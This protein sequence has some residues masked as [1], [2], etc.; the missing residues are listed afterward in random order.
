MSILLSNFL[1]QSWGRPLSHSLKIAFLPGGEDYWRGGLE[2]L[3]NQ[4]QAIK[5]T[6]GKKI[7]TFALETRGHT[8]VGELADVSISLSY[9]RRHSAS[10]IV[11]VGT[12]YVT[13]LLLNTDHIIGSVLSRNDIDAVCG[14]GLTCRYDGVP[15]L[16]WLSDFQH[17]YYPQFFTEEERRIMNESYLQMIKSSSRILLYS[18][19]VRLDLEKFAPQYAHKA[20]V[21]HPAVAIPDW[22]YAHDP[23]SVVKKYSLPRKFF[24][25]PNNFAKHKNHEIVIQAVHKLSQ[26]GV[27]VVVVF[28]GCED[29]RRPGYFGQL[30]RRVSELGVRDQIVYAGFL[31]HDDLLML[32]RQSISV[33]SPSLFEGWGL[34]VTEARSL[35]KRVLVSDIPP[36]REQDPPEA[37]YFNPT[38][39]LELA[40]RMAEIWAKTE[41][42]PDLELEAN[43]RRDTP[44][45]LRENAERFVA[46]VNEVITEFN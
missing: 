14:L 19:A 34:T 38:D 27:N 35:G 20:R 41:P 40:D 39:S 8:K 25:L 7:T 43:A 33:L 36:F 26:R 45:L 6:F 10:W 12:N 24:Y 31:P 15:S 37:I 23:E 17:M 44:S 2:L 3:K 46:I 32:M 1:K 16:S 22:A 42:G 30:W 18:E 29:H 13:H 5:Q 11:R 28:D 4:I 9:P 21:L